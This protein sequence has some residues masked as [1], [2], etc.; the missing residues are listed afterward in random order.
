MY[1]NDAE[2]NTAAIPSLGAEDEARGSKIKMWERGE[3]KE[4]R[5]SQESD[6]ISVIMWAGRSGCGVLINSANFSI[7][8][9]WLPAGGRWKRIR[10]SDDDE[11]RWLFP[12]KVSQLARR[13]RRRHYSRII[14]VPHETGTAA[15]GRFYL[16]QTTYID[17]SHLF[18]LVRATRLWVST[19]QTE[20]VIRNTARMECKTLRIIRS[21]AFCALR[22]RVTAN[23][24]HSPVE[25]AAII[26]LICTVK[27][28]IRIIRLRHSDWRS[29][30]SH[31]IS[32]LLPFPSLS[33]ILLIL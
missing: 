20:R 9:T 23:Y 19:R 21:V 30:K 33:R 31:S 18:A 16:T 11:K 22:G 12:A 28:T 3:K 2:M 26:I 10:R 25:A 5:R 32:F 14:R 1:E 8:A 24:F 7:N 27:V 15:G 6:C 17:N 29:Q 13:L 4:G